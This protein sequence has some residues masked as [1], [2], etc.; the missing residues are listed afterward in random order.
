[1]N[2]NNNK[3]KKRNFVTNPIE[4][5]KNTGNAIVQAREVQELGDA[6]LQSLRNDLASGIKGDLLNQ[7]FDVEPKFSANIEVGES[8]KVDTDQGRAIS[9]MEKQLHY[10]RSLSRSEAELIQ[11][12]EQELK[13]ELMEIAKEVVR[14]VKETNELA[15]ELK[16]AAMQVQTTEGNST[17]DKFFLKNLLI[18]IKGYVKRIEVAKA[19][20][21]M[22]N[23]RAQKKGWVANYNAQGAKYLLSGEHYVV[24][25]AG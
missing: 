20:L 14:T 19:G 9:A 21:H 6:M 22:Q 16:I 5:L 25:S 7:V 12:R 23:S 10:E 15:E 18:D 17:Y 24:R 8:V 1:M 2:N 4:T 3:K 11:K 13:A